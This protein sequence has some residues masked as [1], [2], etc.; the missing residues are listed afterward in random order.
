LLQLLSPGK[1]NMK[2]TRRR[3]T[4][5]MHIDFLVA[6]APVSAASPSPV[7]VTSS[8][9]SSSST[10]SSIINTTVSTS[11]SYHHEADNVQTGS[12]KRIKL[13]SSPTLSEN[14]GDQATN[15][16]NGSKSKDETTAG[17]ASVFPAFSLTVKYGPAPSSPADSGISMSENSTTD[18]GTS[19]P[20]PLRRRRRTVAVDVQIPFSLPDAEAND[21]T[22]D[23]IDRKQYDSW[24][25]FQRRMVETQEAAQR[26]V[27]ASGKRDE[28]VIEERQIDCGAAAPAHEEH[29]CRCCMGQ[30]MPSDHHLKRQHHGEPADMYT[31]SRVLLLPPC[32]RS[33]PEASMYDHP[34]QTSA[35]QQRNTCQ[36]LF[37]PLPSTTPRSPPLNVQSRP[38]IMT[39]FPL[40]PVAGPSGSNNEE[41][42]IRTDQIVMR[43]SASA[44]Q[45]ITTSPPDFHAHI[46]HQPFHSN[47][48]DTYQ[49]HQHHQCTCP[50]ST[51]S[52]S[53]VLEHY[54]RHQ[55]LNR[56]LT[57]KERQEAISLA[58]TST[59]D[60]L[61]RMQDHWY[62]YDRG[63]YQRRE[64][65]LIAHIAD[66]RECRDQRR[67]EERECHHHH[68]Q[69]HQQHHHQ[70]QPHRQRHF[71]SWSEG[72]SMRYR[73][74]QTE[75]A[76]TRSPH[77]PTPHPHILASP[78]THPTRDA[79]INPAALPVLRGVLVPVSNTPQ[80]PPQ[81]QPQSQPQQAQVQPSPQRYIL[82]RVVPVPVR[83]GAGGSPRGAG[84]CG[85]D[86]RGG[87]S[88]ALGVGRYISIR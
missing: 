80:P 24:E 87:E 8:V 64:R 48:D 1:V 38:I 57:V 81:P 28:I 17:N 41:R 77:L 12:S 5:V 7:N 19:A 61:K 44:S 70:P 67:W 85:A 62:E 36:I 76:E 10:L 29:N 50:P 75:S 65:E 86:S 2:H 23:G 47:H 71:R 21:N 25:G 73:P 3:T 22:P 9:S 27:G 78:S 69:H 88:P 6:Q 40:A 84:D 72:M 63:L 4:S 32:P 46:P 53:E 13:S 39:S 59:E 54:R 58:L 66:M 68:Q 20:P 51:T 14:A 16:S 42:I 52:L 34:H 55:H 43:R 49:Q 79:L 56:P 45:S 83:S 60:M 15:E 74:Y 30:Q 26:G 82:C 31:P 35:R 33:A 11:H 18:M 37:P